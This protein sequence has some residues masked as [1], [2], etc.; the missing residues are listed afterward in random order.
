VIVFDGECVLCS[1]FF[2][3]VLRHDCDQ[4]FRFVLAQS[5]LGTAIYEALG[6]PTCE[7]DTNVVIRDG[8]ICLRGAS[9]PHAMGG[10]PSPW[11]ALSVLRHVPPVIADP[12]YHLIARNR[13]RIFGRFDQCMIPD[14]A[15]RARFLPGG[16]T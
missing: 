14:A 2:R 5:P 8:L 6:Q 4:R 10:L 15:L 13:Y 7:F 3:F 11:S 12:A 9:F 16:S 1:R